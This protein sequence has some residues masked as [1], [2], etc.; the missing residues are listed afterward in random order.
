MKN[1][2]ARLRRN[3]Q[4][5][6]MQ[7]AEKEFAQ[8]KP[9]DH[10]FSEIPD[11][12]WQRLKEEVEAANGK[13]I[14]LVHPFFPASEGHDARYITT[15]L[16]LLKQRKTPV[17]ILEE[18]HGIPA[19][20]ASLSIMRAAPGHLI[21]AT[22]NLSHC[23]ASNLTKNPSIEPNFR[24]FARRLKATG[25]KM[26]YVGDRLTYNNPDH[27]EL[28]EYERKILG[29]ES[30]GQIARGCAGGAYQQ[31][32]ESGEFKVRPLTSAMFPYRPEWSAERNLQPIKPLARLP[33]ALRAYR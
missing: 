14:V 27:P 7:R 24:H 3:A 13:A 18:A 30:Y 2:L 12:R 23:L 25:I 17:I 11:E 26:L 22:I 10:L 28:A 9:Q 15:V 8:L 20:K 33:R 29:K 16:R 31:L 4:L 19:L 32:A 1:A 21:I 6:T 5:R